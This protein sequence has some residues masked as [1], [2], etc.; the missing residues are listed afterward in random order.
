MLMLL[1]VVRAGFAGGWGGDEGNA[2]YRE[3]EDQLRSLTKK[4]S[5]A[6]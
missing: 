6:E 1:Q 5:E 2:I 3:V 4:P